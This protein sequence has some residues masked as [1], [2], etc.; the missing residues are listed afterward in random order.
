MAGETGESYW[1]IE[2]KTYEK[3]LMKALPHLKELKF[4]RE[5]EELIV[6]FSTP[7][8][9]AI[10]EEKI[11]GSAS[12][13][14]YIGEEVYSPGDDPRLDLVLNKIAEEYNLNYR[15]KRYDGDDEIFKALSEINLND[16]KN[17][18]KKTSTIKFYNTPLFSG[19]PYFG[20]DFTY[21]GNSYKLG[22]NDN[23]VE[24]RKN[25]KIYYYY[26]DYDWG[27]QEYSKGWGKEEAFKELDILIKE[28]GGTPVEGNPRIKIREIF[29]LAI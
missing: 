5:G 9:G 6:I 19:D 8:G 4:R 25:N 10:W 1:Q 3:N 11:D 22:A 12:T 20:I 26:E 24:L 2:Q 23:Y 29:K 18:V 21:K 27:V 7:N 15:I 13:S 28:L 17:S 14:L 16:K